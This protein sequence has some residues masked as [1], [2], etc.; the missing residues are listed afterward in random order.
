MGRKKQGR[1]DP[2]SIS[3]LYPILGHLH[4]HFVL[5][6]LS[7]AGLLAMCSSGGSCSPAQSE[8]GE[9]SR[10]AA[11]PPASPR[12]IEGVAGEGREGVA[13]VSLRPGVKRERYQSKA[14]T[15]RTG[16]REIASV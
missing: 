10:E 16:K 9:R 4:T 12:R 6:G 7:V 11:F 3:R 8:E 15:G 1:G 2:V 14:G 5:A 13:G